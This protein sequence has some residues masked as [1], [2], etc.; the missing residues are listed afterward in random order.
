M[1]TDV[2]VKGVAMADGKWKMA[3]A[4]R[5]AGAPSE[6][7]P[8]W[9]R[10]SH[11]G[12]GLNFWGF[13]CLGAAVFALGLGGLMAAQVETERSF[14]PWAVVAGSF[15]SAGCVLFLFGNLVHIRAAL[16]RIASD[17]D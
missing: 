12:S 5:D 10:L 1:N 6:D 2:E 3:D 8:G 14:W 16:E 13:I 9:E 17:R 11:W 7:V 15:T 4:G